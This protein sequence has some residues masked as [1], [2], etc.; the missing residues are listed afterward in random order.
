MGMMA[1]MRSLAPWFILTVGGLFVLFMVLSDS[2]LTEL[3]GRQSAIIGEINGEE[4]T[5]QQFARL[6]EQ[7]RTNQVQQTGQEIDESQMNLFRD[8]VWDAYISQRLVESKIDEFGLEVTDEE[9]MDVI[10][11]PNPPAFLRNSFID[12]TGNFNRA[13]YD[14]AIYDTRNKEAL[15]QAEEAVRQQRIQEKLQSYVTASVVVSQEE[16]KR[17]YMEKNIM[18]DANYVLVSEAQIRDDELEITDAGLKKFYDEN[19]DL[20]E[21]E[22]QRKLKYVMFRK[23]P[24]ALDSS[25]VKKSLESVVK[26]L[27]ADTSQFKTYVEIYSE[28]PYSIDTVSL[29][30][31]PAEVGSVI[32][33]SEKGEVIGPMLTSQGFAIYKL[34]DVLNSDEEV[35]RASHILVSDQGDQAAAKAEADKVYEQLMAGADFEELARQVSGDKGS[36]VK[37]GDLGWFGKGAMVPEFEQASFSGKIGVIQKPVQTTFGFHIIKVTGRS[38]KKYAVEKIV[39]KIEPTATTIDRIYG[40]AGDFA[41]L[42]GEDGFE[43]TAETYSYITLETPAFKED[44]TSIP[45]IGQNSGLKRFAFEHPVGDVSEVFSINS[46]YVV[47]MVSEVIKAGYKPFDEVK[48][49][50]KIGYT[51]QLKKQKTMEIAKRIHAELKPGNLQAATSVY[52]KAIVK[53]AKNF[54]AGINVPG[55]GRDFAFISAALEIPVNTVSEPILGNKG[56]YIIEVT[57]RTDFDE[58]KFAM[59]RNLLRDQLLQ[60]K[61]SRVFN[62]WVDNLAKAA[63]VKDYR[64]KFY[65]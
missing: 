6:V 24:S 33:S 38:D 21:V 64:F 14:E 7:A 2:K 56:A 52:D 22:P 57:S 60:Q 35:V 48:A 61:K 25:S 17:T 1:R 50:A 10:A 59:Q 28:E 12:S 51:R 43:K 65:R 4:V 54:T 41:Y 15:I 32:T 30:R 58:S 20:Y 45:G 62:N 37:G 31:I 40:K 34:N 29:T 13:M 36:A 39:R 49:Q 19:L 3:V 46:G 8:R 18:M 11:G 9:I 16:L 27:K 44:A 42:A 5:Y 23:A 26:K 47:V 53:D 63:D 55:V